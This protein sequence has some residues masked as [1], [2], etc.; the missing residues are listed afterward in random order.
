MNSATGFC[1]RWRR[2]AGVVVHQNIAK[3]TF[4]VLCL[5]VDRDSKMIDTLGEGNEIDMAKVTEH[6]CYE[7]FVYNVY[8][9][10]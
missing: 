1:K 4:T 3:F 10:N 5:T 8:I 6:L 9:T 7:V 2:E